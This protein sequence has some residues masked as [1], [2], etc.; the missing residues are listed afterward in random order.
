MEFKLGKKPAVK[1]AVTFKLKDYVDRSILPKPPKTFGH[2]GI[3]GDDWLMLGNDLYGDCVF[4]GAAHETMMW[5]MEAGIEVRFDDAAV[6]HNYSEVTGFNPADPDS[7][8]GTNMSEA[9]SYRRKTGLIDAEGVRH[10]VA[11]YLS[12]EPGNIAE[13]YIAMYLFGAIGIGILF[14]DTAMDQFARR[15]PWKVVKGAHIEGGHYVSLVARREDMKCVTWGRIQ[16]MSKTFFKKY[17]DESIAYVSHE[18]LIEGKTLEGFDAD[19]LIACLNAL[20]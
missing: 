12:I 13:H 18:R 10:T 9:A 16:G 20:K 2:E 14:P 6:L 7:D 1:G 11:A 3:I 15:Q 17:N 8:N 5:N 4:A 19:G